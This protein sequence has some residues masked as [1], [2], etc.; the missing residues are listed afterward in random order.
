MFF[1]EVTDQDLPTC[2]GQ[3]CWAVQQSGT[4]GQVERR[5]S[6]FSMMKLSSSIKAKPWQHVLGKVKRMFN[7]NSVGKRIISGCYM[8]LCCGKVF[9]KAPKICKS[10]KP[11]YTGSSRALSGNSRTQPWL[12]NAVSSEHMAHS[13]KSSPRKSCTNLGLYFSH[14]GLLAFPFLDIA[15]NHGM[16]LLVSPSPTSALC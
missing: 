9:K 13:C 16:C 12:W 7:I 1:H 8:Q 14:E 11:A 4:A 10:T 3:L 6:R 15:R 5:K 2:K